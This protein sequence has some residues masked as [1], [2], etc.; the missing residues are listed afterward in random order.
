MVYLMNVDPTASPYLQ[1]NYSP[2]HHLVI[3]IKADPKT[4]KGHRETV[5]LKISYTLEEL[6]LESHIRLRLKTNAS[7]EDIG[8][9]RTLLRQSIDHRGARRS[10]RSL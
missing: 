3:C 10:Q 7:T 4:R 8:Q 1:N 9:S 2:C 5:A 6:V